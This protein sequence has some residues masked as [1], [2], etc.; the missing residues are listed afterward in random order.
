MQLYGRLTHTLNAP[1]P[2]IDERQGIEPC[3]IKNDRR[4]GSVEKA[5]MA[6]ERLL[7]LNQSRQNESMSVAANAV[8]IQNRFEGLQRADT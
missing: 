4:F 5:E 2:G 7:G 8:I 1:M 3:S 6:P